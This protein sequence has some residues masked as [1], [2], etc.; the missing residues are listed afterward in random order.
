MY[1]DT[2]VDEWVGKNKLVVVQLQ[3]CI[4][5]N[6]NVLYYIVI[7]YVILQCIVQYHTYSAVG[8]S[9]IRYSIVLYGFVLY[10][11][12]LQCLYCTIPY[13]TVGFSRIQ[14]SPLHLRAAM[15]GEARG[16]DVSLRPADLT[17]RVG[18]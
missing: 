11:V 16:C 4:I 6:C 3:Y 8:F 1:F 14:Y 13:S 12:I 17:E 9:R 15:R 2:L 5:V 10:C 18:P 7:Y